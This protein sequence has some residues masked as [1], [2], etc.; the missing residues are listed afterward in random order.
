MLLLTP[1]HIVFNT[2]PLSIISIATQDILTSFS[3]MVVILR[4]FK[5]D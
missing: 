1:I 4:P 2:I 3:Q 5:K